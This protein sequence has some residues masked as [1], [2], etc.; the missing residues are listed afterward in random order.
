M[1]VVWLTIYL[2]IEASS[3]T[4]PYFVQ[5]LQSLPLY[6]LSGTVDGSSCMSDNA[7]TSSCGYQTD[8]TWSIST[9][10]KLAW[11]NLVFEG[12]L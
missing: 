11:Q 9:H 4:E 1:H 10:N 7:F 6:G 5:T 2:H 3:E 12:G 8:H